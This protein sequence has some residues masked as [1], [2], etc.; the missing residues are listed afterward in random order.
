M[1]AVKCEIFFKILSPL[2]EDTLYDCQYNY[3]IRTKF[4]ISKPSKLLEVIESTDTKIFSFVPE[5]NTTDDFRVQED[6]A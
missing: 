4:N 3:E 1:V 2:S 6:D 5:L